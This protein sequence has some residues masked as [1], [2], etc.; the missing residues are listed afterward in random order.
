[1]DEKQFSYPLELGVSMF[2][3]RHALKVSAY[4]ELYMQAVEPHLKNI[5]M[6]EAKLSE[7][8]VRMLNISEAITCLTTVGLAWGVWRRIKTIQ[9]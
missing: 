6:D 4:Q 9:H 3:G 5:G 1:M 8:M 7:W 2:S